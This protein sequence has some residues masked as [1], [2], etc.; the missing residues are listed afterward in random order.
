MLLSWSCQTG[1]MLFPAMASRPLTFAK[2]M[3]RFSEPRCLIFGHRRGRKMDPFLV[4]D[5]G[6]KNGA[7]VPWLNAKYVK[8]PENV[9]VFGPGIWD[10]KL[11]RFLVR[12]G[13]KSGTIW[14]NIRGGGRRAES[15]PRLALGEHCFNGACPASPRGYRGPHTRSRGLAAKSQSF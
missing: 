14:A 10:E 4:P 12:K 1:H 11:V 5:S 8:G 13:T 3:V 2:C 7:V 6:P 9:P 15:P